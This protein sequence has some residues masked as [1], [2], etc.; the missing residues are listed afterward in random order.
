MNLN[1]IFEVSKSQLLNTKLQTQ[2]GVKLEDQDRARAR[3]VLVDQIIEADSEFRF[4]L[5]ISL[6]LWT[7]GGLLSTQNPCHF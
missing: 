3:R 5:V 4:L 6:S 1:D 2:S 7:V